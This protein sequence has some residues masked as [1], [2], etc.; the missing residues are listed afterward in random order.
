MKATYW[1]RGEAIDYKN[2][3]DVTIPENTVI[4]IKTRIGVTGTVIEPG[5]TGSLHVCGI[6][7]LPKSDAGELEIGTIV[8]SDGA[9]VTASADNSKTGD[10]KVVYVPAGYVVQAAAAADSTALVKLLG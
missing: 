5:Q 8:Y 1:Q 10:E 4:A 3:T 7:E 9:G 6:F 2:T